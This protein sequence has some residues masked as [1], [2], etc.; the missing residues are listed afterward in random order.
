ME[1]SASVFQCVCGERHGLCGGTAK[2]SRRNRL[3]FAVEDAERVPEVVFSIATRREIYQVTMEFHEQATA[4]FTELAQDV[5]AKVGLFG[6]VQPVTSRPTGIHPV[7]QFTEK[8]IIGPVN[9][10]DASVN[11]LGQETGRFWESGGYRVGWAGKEYEAVKSLAARL[12]NTSPLKGLVSSQ[13]VL[14][15]VFVWLRE[16]LEKKRSDTLT[17]FITQRCSEK[18]KHHEIWV[19]VYRTY[20]RQNFSIGNV[21]FRTISQSMLDQWYSRIP[22][23]Q[24]KNEP[25]VDVFLSRQRSTLQGTIAACVD[26]DAEPIKA[27][28]TA[29]AAADDAVALLRLLSEVNWTCRI[30]SYCLPMG[31][32]NARTTMDITVEEGSIRSIG[33]ATVEQG[34]SAWNIDQARQMPLC[35][36]LL[37]VLHDLASNRSKSEF[38]TDLYGALLLHARHSVATEVAHKLVFVVAAAESIFLKNSSE[39]IQK[40]LGERMAFLIGEAIEERRKVIQNVDEFYRVRSGLIHHGRDIQEGQKDIVD[41]FFFNVWFSFVRLLRNLDQWKTRDEMF[42]FLENRKL[43]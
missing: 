6:Q 22:E 19:P 35:V 14:D 42:S 30:T 36:G 2:I 15:E 3:S 4:R 23:E 29:H 24:R 9:W 20:S 17:A 40:N 8:D 38:R 1:K 41:E 34:P 27:S 7:A 43:A 11:G 39:P 21:Q 13:F 37:E 10:K 26:V 25:G 5:L 12:E 31:K 16:T 18:I 28:E 32:E 33:R